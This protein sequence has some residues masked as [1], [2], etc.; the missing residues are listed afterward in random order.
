MNTNPVLVDLA[1]EDARLYQL[2]QQITSLPRRLQELESQRR[3]LQRQLKDCEAV[4]EKTEKERR[5]LELDLQEMR[6]RRAKSEARQSAV[7]STESLQALEREMQKQDAR[8]DELESLVLEAMDRSA[9][10]EKRRYGERARLEAEARRLDDLQLQL[11]EDLS[12]AKSG[13]GAQR[14]K[15]DGLV[16]QLEPATRSLYERVLR[17]KGDAAIA[18]MEDR[19]CGICSALQPPQV[20]QELRAASATLHTCQICGRILVSDSQGSSFP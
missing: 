8:I 1:R 9:E 6:Q 13:I 19:K 4:Y 12:Q 17:A 2:R 18:L 3:Q 5:K 10:A 16:A 15:R 14:Q 11:E 20:V 7:T